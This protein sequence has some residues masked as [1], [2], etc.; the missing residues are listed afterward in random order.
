MGER[1][2]QV[3]KAAKSIGRPGIGV[4]GDSALPDCWE[5]NQV[6][7]KNSAFS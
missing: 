3:P 4:T 6:L 7:C 5:P 2:V 1:H